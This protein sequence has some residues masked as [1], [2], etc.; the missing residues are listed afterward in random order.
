VAAD[1]RA[2]IEALESAG[3]GINSDQTYLVR[4]FVLGDG[5]DLQY[6]ITTSPI[7]YHVPLS[8]L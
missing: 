6:W 4:E 5:A 3:A 1:G 2:V 8:C 7:L